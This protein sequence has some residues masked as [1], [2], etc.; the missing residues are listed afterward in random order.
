MDLNI[1][2]EYGIDNLI[3]QEEIDNIINFIIECYDKD[4]DTKP[5]EEYISYLKPYKI[6]ND[7]TKEFKKISETLEKKAI[8]LL[9]KEEEEK[10]K[11][12]ARLKN[13]EYVDFEADP[14]DLLFSTDILYDRF[15]EESFSEESKTET[16]IESTVNQLFN[17]IFEEFRQIA[18]FKISDRKNHRIK[19]GTKIDLNKY[20]HIECGDQI[21]FLAEGGWGVADKNGIVLI[22]NH[23]K[24]QPSKSDPII[25][26]RD[27]FKLNDK[28]QLYKSQDCDSELYGVISKNPLKE[29][30][31]TEYHE[32]KY[33]AT[34]KY[35]KIFLVIRYIKNTFDENE[36]LIENIY[37]GYGCFNENC[38]QITDF[39]Y[40]K[41]E[42]N[43]NYIECGRDG[44]FY[45]KD[46]EYDEYGICIFS[47]P[48]T[49][50]SGVYDLY[51]LE[52]VSL[53]K[54]YYKSDF[55]RI[56]TRRILFCFESKKI[57]AKWFNEKNH[58]MFS[59]E[60]FDFDKRQSLLLDKNLNSILKDSNGK[61]FSLIDNHVDNIE[62]IPFSFIIPGEI[63]YDNEE[64]IISYIN[65]YDKYFESILTH[66]DYQFGGKW[67]DYMVDKG[68]YYITHIDKN[69]NV[70]WHT[71]VDNYSLNNSIINIKIGTREGI[72]TPKGIQL[73]NV[74]YPIEIEVY[75]DD[76]IYK[77]SEDEV[78]EI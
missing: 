77:Q 1:L 18:C 58:E 78:L 63:V 74:T 55:N 23:L 59:N 39:I 38:K 60:K 69:G 64:F 22:S 5:N 37:D 45:S 36:R 31:P 76:I 53:L 70:D 4:N 8:A 62:Q 30:L 40:D 20:K 11:E 75:V 65:E 17:N 52:G 19:K 21:E 32:I 51:N 16:P 34:S 26:S 29:L 2:S 46:N 73:S 41:I 13:P 71:I 48:N 28:R 25:Y 27:Y 3:T 72:I 47:D 35:E 67:V 9:K 57:A 68:V 42:I 61:Y 33:I 44:I 49:Y 66:T 50:Y 10:E 6:F 14:S 43:N 56:F 24:K 7:Y 15:F 12:E 54:G